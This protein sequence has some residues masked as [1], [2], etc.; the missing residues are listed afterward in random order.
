[1]IKF[2]RKIRQNLLSE[3]KF[4]KYLIYAIGE[5]ILVVIGILI[6]LQLNNLN[7]ERKNREF[8]KEILAQIEENLNNDKLALKQIVNDFSLAITSSEKVLRSKVSDK[9]EDS[10]KVWLGN[11]I[12]FDRFQPLTNAYEVLKSKGLDK[13]S[14]KKLRFLLGK[15]YDDEASHMVKSTNDIEL[16]FNTHW[17]PIL[18]D[19]MVEFEF[20]KSVELKDYK[21]LLNPSKAQNILKLNRDNLASGINRLNIG[22]ATIVKIQNLIEEEIK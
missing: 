1:M 20:K 8:E 21:I 15:Y 6:A 10:I 19:E 13:I 14:N 9:T 22:L 16:T 2:F 4:S 11:I 12:M 3:N 5:I 17:L 18:F 7:E